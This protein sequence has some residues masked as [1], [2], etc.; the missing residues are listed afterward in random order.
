M[1]IPDV[2]RVLV[3]FEHTCLV[4]VKHDT[5]ATS[6]AMAE[7][8][9]QPNAAGASLQASQQGLSHTEAEPLRLVVK[10]APSPVKQEH[11]A[12]GAFLLGRHTSVARLFCSPPRFAFEKKEKKEG[13]GRKQAAILCTCVW[14]GGHE[15]AQC[16]RVPPCGAKENVTH[17]IRTQ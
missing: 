16:P 17:T 1:Y 13:E 7:P 12:P 10:D 6:N 2:S 15:L 8:L 5:A 14:P 11:T 3:L 9:Q 4:Q